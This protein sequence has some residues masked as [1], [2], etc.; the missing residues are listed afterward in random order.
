MKREY[1]EFI[2]EEIFCEEI[3]GLKTYIVPKKNYNQAFALISVKYGSNDIVFSYGNENFHEYPLGIAHFL[4]HKLFEQKEGNLFEK[5]ANLGASPNAYTNFK[6]TTYYF[7]C[8]ENFY[9]NLELLIKFV[10]NPYFT[11]ENVEKEKGIIE[12]EIKMYEDNP[13]FK[14]YFNTMLA[15]YK[16]HPVRND[17]A[18]TVESIHK[19]TPELLYECYNTFYKPE[20]MVMVIVG[21]IEPERVISIGNKIVPFNNEGIKFERYIFNGEEGVKERTIKSNLGLSIPNFVI[22]FK[23]DATD[24]KNKMINKIV[25]FD[26]ITFLLFGRSSKLY[27]DLYEKGLINNSFS[28]EY[29]M[30]T[31][32]SH[33]IIHGESKNPEKVQEI[34]LNALKKVGMNKI[35]DIEFNRIKKVLIGIFLYKFNNVESLGNTLNEYLLK[36]IDFYNYY[37]ILKEITIENV[38]NRI[39]TIF[40][41]ENYVLSVIN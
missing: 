40:N 9:E 25:E 15:M 17:I 12:Q 5:F 36:N 33:F 38:E 27:E 35:S 23:H 6:N 37:D 34:L 11:E 41:A 21:D 28:S 19:I 16:N 39:N 4:E 32:Y 13:A 8:T 31:D 18:G 22:G 24:N 7:T 26:I 10:F 30:E 3:N 14:V 20:N 29:A 2:D 1:K